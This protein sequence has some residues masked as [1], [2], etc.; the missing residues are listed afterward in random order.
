MKNKHV[1]KI[2][3]SVVVC[4]YN[5]AEKIEKCL[6]SLLNQNY[7]KDKYEII[8]IDDGSTDQTYQIVKLYPVKI[9]KHKKN[10][11]LAS[12]RNTGLKYA[13]GYIYACFDDDCI[14]N[15]NWLKN[16]VSK[17]T[18]SSIAGV[19][20]L[21]KTPTE[22]ILEKYIYESG[23]AAPTPMIFSNSENLFYRFYAY[24][25]SMYTSIIENKKR[26]FIVYEL[27]G[28]N[29]SF[30]KKILNRVGGWDESLSGHEDIDICH[31]IRERFP[32]KILLCTKDAIIEHKQNLNFIKF[33]RK[34]YDRSD[35]ILW[36]YLKCSKLPPIFPFPIIYLIILLASI[37]FYLN[38]FIFCLILLPQILY[39]NWLTKVFKKRDVRYLLYP[40]IQ[41]S[42]ESF[43]LA[44]ILKSILK[45]IFKE[46]NN[47]P[48]RKY[49][50]HSINK[51]FSAKTI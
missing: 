23:Y 16:L 29:A 44:G 48:A 30:V 4:T 1:N 49:L 27:C 47:S 10:R 6:A 15:K 12:A 2:F 43:F 37:S 25:K 5:G 9:I 39:F 11:G 36:Y 28:A 26:T 8:V 20:G 42:Y 34:P 46:S 24:L 14:A 33:V 22:G 50:N 7:P 35:S 3:I 13:K 19:G 38:S 21:Y 41:L 31:S 32:G 51:F 45:L 18:D 40:Y 17:Y